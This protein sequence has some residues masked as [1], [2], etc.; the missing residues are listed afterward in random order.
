MQCAVEAR[1][2]QSSPLVP[3]A[4]I[5]QPLDRVQARGLSS[6][7][8]RIRPEAAGQLQRMLRDR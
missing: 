1:T 7:T 8:T 2:R 3:T 5:R 4:A 6:D